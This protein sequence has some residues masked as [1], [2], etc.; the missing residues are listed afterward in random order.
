MY[1]IYIFRSDKDRKLYTGYTTDIQQRIIDHN[2]GHVP[3]TKNRRP[4][5]LVF[6]ESYANKD[7]AVRRETYLKT[8]AG[9]KA[10][11]FML[12]TTLAENSSGIL[13]TY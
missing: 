8:S 1:H 4:L 2:R 13:G 5:K 10:I 7:D 3:S 6:L 11:K 9:K 12:R